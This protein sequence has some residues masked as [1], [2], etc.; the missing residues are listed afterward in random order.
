[1]KQPYRPKSRSGFSLASSLMQTQIRTASESRGFAVSRLLTHW[2]EIVGEATASVALPVS[3]TYG[4]DGLGATLTVLTTGAQAP[5]V[6]MQKDQIR[7]KVNACYGYRAIAKVRITQTAPTGF[8]EGR[9]DW[10]HAPKQPLAPDPVVQAQARTIA[11][12]VE[13]DDLRLALQALA[14]NVLA[15]QKR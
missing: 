12:G 3:V 15:K 11:Q 13:S 4:R 6:E 9:I 2:S 7:D 1:M 10:G 8:S 14:A 5:M